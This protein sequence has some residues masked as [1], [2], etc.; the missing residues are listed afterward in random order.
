MKNETQLHRYKQ[1]LTFI[2]KNFKKDINI[3]DIE[4]ACHYS[5]RNINRIF[6]ALHQET[7]GKYIKRKRLEKAAEYLKYTQESVSDIAY[8]VGFGDVAAFSKAFKSKFKCSPSAFREE[9]YQLSSDTS[10]SH[11]SNELPP[12]AFEIIKL[13]A[14]QTLSLTYRGSY[15][16]LEAIQQV[17]EQ[18]VM[19]ANSQNLL[20]ENT[21]YLASI[22]D[23]DEISE[24]IH[25]RYQAA[26]T[27]PETLHFTPKALFNTQL[28]PA[29][30]Y[31]KFLHHGAH[32]KSP[33]TYQHIYS[34]WLTHIQ[35]EI[36]DVPILEVYLN[37]EDDTPQEELLTEI[38][39]PIR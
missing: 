5:Y 22:L 24:A 14:F 17:W 39:I 36:A 10:T 13:P 30:K 26:I 21:I 37:D 27:L 28:I 29:Q 25:C 1:L 31:A 9:K 35:L 8:D 33:E 18:L 32:Q 3:P 11:F 38:Y 7:I 15:D 23:D 12:I 20:T 4:E 19:Y 6:H 16:D 2:E 34:Q